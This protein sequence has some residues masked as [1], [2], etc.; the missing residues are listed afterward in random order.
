MRGG[1]DYFVTMKRATTPAEDRLLAKCRH[2]TECD[3]KD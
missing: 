2:E 1:A 3:L